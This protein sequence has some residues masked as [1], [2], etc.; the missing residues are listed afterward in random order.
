M[1]LPPD[2]IIVK[3]LRTHCTIG[4]DRWGK[5]R[6]QPL[7][8]SIKIDASLAACCKSDDVADSIHYGHLAKDVSKLVDGSIFSDLGKAAESVADMVLMMDTRVVAVE[9][10]AYAMNQ[11]LQAESLGVQLRRKQGGNSAVEVQVDKVLIKDLRVNI[12]I[13]LNPPEREAKQVVIIN[14]TLHG[15]NWS[16][17]DWKK[18]HAILVHVRE[19]I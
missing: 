7:I 17:Q 3:D 8:I 13:G 5:L 4:S 2:T 14:L 9:V 19:Q 18:T 16:K 10:E 11:F 6:D 1:N 12:I 15:I